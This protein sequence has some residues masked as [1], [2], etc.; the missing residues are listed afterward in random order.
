MCIFTYTHLDCGH[1]KQDHIDTSSCNYFEHNGVH[2]QPDSRQHRERGTQILTQKRAGNCA[3]CAQKIQNGW[4]PKEL[5]A[6][7]KASLDAAGQDSDARRREQ[8]R[9][10]DIQ[11]ADQAEKARL[12]RDRT[13]LAQE[14]I[15]R[16]AEKEGRRKEERRL[17]KE[18]EKEQRRQEEIRLADEETRRQ[19]R[20]DQ[21]RREQEAADLRARSDKLNQAEHERRLQKRR[22]EEARRWEQEEA[23]HQRYI[24]AQQDKLDRKSR[25]ARENDETERERQAEA[26]REAS[27]REQ[28][29][30]PKDEESKH[31]EEAEEEEKRT[32]EVEL[33]AKKA[34]N[35]EMERALLEA[36]RKSPITSSPASPVPPH[37]PST[38]AKSSATPRVLDPAKLIGQHS[39]PEY[40]HLRI[41]NRPV[42]L[43][44][45]Q[46]QAHTPNTPS[47]SSNLRTPLTPMGRLAGTI[48]ASP[49]D[50]IIQHPS[51]VVSGL[52]SP[53]PEWKRNLPTRTTS[54]DRV[55]MVKTDGV[56][57]LAA[58]LQKR[59]A[60]E[61]EAEDS[62]EESAS[63]S[64]E[65]RDWASTPASRSS[66]P[67]SSS[68]ALPLPTYPPVPPLA[69]PRVANFLPL[70]TPTAPASTPVVSKPKPP[71]PVK[72]ISINHTSS[73]LPTPTLSA[74]SASPAI[75]PPPPM[76]PFKAR[77][78]VDSAAPSP[79]VGKEFDA[80]DVFGERR[81]RGWGVDQADTH[82]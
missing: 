76:P 77:M 69:H 27:L 55:P 19:K 62:D 22:E 48:T 45:S 36:R 9:R 24:Q 65:Q 63:L 30:Q 34:A 74:S 49:N 67:S 51:M 32:L 4:D 1:R 66:T 2:C 52:D 82:V 75:P 71:V 56:D 73:P 6:A 17:R 12:A 29:Q 72:R 46:K 70:S 47:T 7:I 25:R 10:E 44:P 16:E 23:E 28:F 78:R 79:A 50:Y 54:S 37:V 68:S 3:D 43:H 42:P 11:R 18:A 81:R 15:D 80:G 61:A 60:W 58:R 64:K 31:Q 53:I 41:G 33:A 26:Q 39:I 40:G 20:A 35:D 5:A 59:R 57:E 13:R 21:K 14:Q 38:N 8:K